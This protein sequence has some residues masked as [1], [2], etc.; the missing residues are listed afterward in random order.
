MYGTVFRVRP[1]PGQ[2]EAL[3]EEAARWN[4]E[5]RPH[6][7]G[8]VAEFIYRSDTHPG[9]YIV[10]LVFESREAF[11][12]NANDPEEDSWY[13]RWSEYLTAEPEW[14]DGEVVHRV[15]YAT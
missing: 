6:I 5:R 14:D 15:I 10:A 7:R 13:R 3:I 9:E 8:L 2:E 1:R 11:Q 4:R 12:R